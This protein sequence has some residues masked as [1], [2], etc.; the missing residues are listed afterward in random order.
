[1]TAT[2]T[3]GRVVA[4]QPTPAVGR[5]VAKQTTLTATPIDKQIKGT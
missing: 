4:K 2:P 5:V 3:A 1:M